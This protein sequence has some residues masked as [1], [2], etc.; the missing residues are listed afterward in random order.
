MQLL[1]L[2]LY[3]CQRKVIISSITS[4]Y[5]MRDPFLDSVDLPSLQCSLLTLKIKGIVPL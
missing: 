2:L 1:N 4:P 3:F 5:A